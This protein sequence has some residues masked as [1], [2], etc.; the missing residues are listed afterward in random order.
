MIGDNNI[1]MP[2]VQF[3]RGIDVTAE[4]LNGLQQYL[5]KELSE[6]TR[7]LIKYAGFAWGLK[8]G[9]IDGQS[10]TITQGVGFD[11]YGTRLYQNS[12]KAYKLTFPAAAGT[13]GFLC[14]KSTPTDVQYK[15]H[16]YDGTRHPVETVIALQFYI[17]AGAALY[18][19]SIGNLYGPDNNGLVLAKLWIDGSSYGWDDVTSTSRSPN[20]TMR[21]GVA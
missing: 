12:D 5:S 10:I 2:G 8:V 18:I 3:H 19:D 7:D 17:A 16:P 15:V 1:R 13:E 6:R 20:L 4:T 21:D 14:V 9:R 11:Q